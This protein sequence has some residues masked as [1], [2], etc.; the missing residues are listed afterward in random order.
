MAKEHNT[1]GPPHLQVLHPQI[2]PS[3]D[4]KY[5]EKKFQKSPKSK[6]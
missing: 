2:Q 5:L 4:L 3:M 1:V 6:T